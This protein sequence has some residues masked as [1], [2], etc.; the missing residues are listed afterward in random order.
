MGVS[1]QEL[2]EDCYPW[3]TL[4][5]IRGALTYFYDHLARCRGGCRNRR[6]NARPSLLLDENISYLGTI[7]FVQWLIKL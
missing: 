6:M 2:A 1:V 3:L 7:S 4:A 5:E